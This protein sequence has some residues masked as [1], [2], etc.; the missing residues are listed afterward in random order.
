MDKDEKCVY[1]KSLN[2]DK[3]DDMLNFINFNNLLLCQSHICDPTQ[4]GHSHPPNV[5]PVEM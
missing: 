1:S 5:K 3:I 4:M 2:S